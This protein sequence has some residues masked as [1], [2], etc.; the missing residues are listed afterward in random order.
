[1]AIERCTK[2]HALTVGMNAKFLFNLPKVELFIVENVIETIE[3]K[4][5]YC[6]E[7]Y[8]ITKNLF[9]KL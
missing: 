5:F 1:M 9:S 7:F 3:D 2:L 6:F 8:D 4:L